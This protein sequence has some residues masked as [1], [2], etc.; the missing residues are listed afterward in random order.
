[1]RPAPI[2]SSV[3]THPGP[4]DLRNDPSVQAWHASITGMLELLAVHKVG[5]RG[6]G[7][8]FSTFSPSLTSCS[9][10]E[11]SVNHLGILWRPESSSGC[12]GNQAF[13]GVPTGAVMT[14]VRS[15]SLHLLSSGCVGNI[16][17]FGVPTGAV[18]TEVRRRSLLLFSMGSA[19]GVSVAR[20]ASCPLVVPN[21]PATV[22]PIAPV[23][24][25]ESSSSHFWPS[26][27]AS[28]P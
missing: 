1:V 10:L 8:V 3:I 22:L 28:T 4:A 14:E 26:H 19:G 6:R 24:L 7:K 16:A 17:F 9:L 2:L 12:V 11:A 18:M 27:K 25:E 23:S 20:I 5:R 21:M 13:F 15:G